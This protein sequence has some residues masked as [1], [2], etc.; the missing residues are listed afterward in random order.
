MTCAD[1][2][3]VDELTSGPVTSL[4]NKRN[5]LDIIGV[6]LLLFSPQS[7]EN[8]RSLSNSEFRM[9]DLVKLCDLPAEL[10]KV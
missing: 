9:G 6:V 10:R 4:R 3:E 8:D 7:V 2:V 1:D 5:L